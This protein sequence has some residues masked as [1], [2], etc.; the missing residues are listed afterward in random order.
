MILMILFIILLF[1]IICFAPRNKSYN[2]H[3][4]KHLNIIL[5][6]NIIGRYKVATNIYMH[7]M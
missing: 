2:T 3:K 6:R 1:C 7:F 5:V 4:S